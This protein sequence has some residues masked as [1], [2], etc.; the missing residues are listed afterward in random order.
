MSLQASPISSSSFSTSLS[1]CFRATYMTRH[2]T[3]EF[4]SNEV[5]FVS[6]GHFPPSFP[7][8][9]THLIHA[10]QRVQEPPINRQ[11]PL[12]HVAPQV[13]PRVQR[14]FRGIHVG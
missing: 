14:V 12:L 10:V 11:L 8:K 3:R 5:E 9:E 13:S 7:S 2:E 6:V 4:N 1:F